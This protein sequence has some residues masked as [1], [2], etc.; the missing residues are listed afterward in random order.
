MENEKMRKC[1]KCGADIPMDA[2]YCD[3]C[4]APVVIPQ[5]PDEV[6]KDVPNPKE[7][8]RQYLQIFAMC[9]VFVIAFSICIAL[10]RGY[11]NRIKYELREKREDVTGWEVKVS[12][13]ELEKIKIGM[14]YEEVKEIVGG[15]GKLIESN[16]FWISY[17]WPGEYQIDRYRGYMELSFAKYNYEAGKEEEPELETIIEYDV[18]NGKEISETHRIMERMDYSKLSDTIIS[19]NQFAKIEN[20]MTYEQVCELLG[21]EGRMFRSY[22]YTYTNRKDSYE[23]YVWRCKNN[24]D[25]RHVEQPFEDGVVKETQE[26]RLKY[27]D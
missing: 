9:A 27:I 10:F 7:R 17:R 2:L 4:G 21:A 5:I 3:V 20:G 24:G 23:E 18:A 8:R 1:T 19:K 22:S 15:D 16:E 12:A 14:S 25:D 13:E 26:W 6:K 11:H